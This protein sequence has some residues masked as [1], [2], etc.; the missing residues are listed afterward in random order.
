MQISFSLQKV[1]LFAT[2]SKYGYGSVQEKS[3]S[4][5]QISF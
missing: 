2:R 5:I 4:L 3:L 1:K